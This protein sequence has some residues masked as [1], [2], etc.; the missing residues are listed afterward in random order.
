VPG[1]QGASPEDQSSVYDTNYGNMPV[2]ATQFAGN[3]AALHSLDKQPSV[4]TTAANASVVMRADRRNGIAYT[5]GYQS[6]R[7][8]GPQINNPVRSSGFQQWLIGP[9]VDFILN[10]CLY[11]AGYPAATISYGTNRNLAWS[12]RVAQIPT[13]ATGGPGPGAMLPAPRFQS[14]QTV[15]RYSTMPTMYNTQSSPG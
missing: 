13:M 5:G 15:P 6:R 9:Q 11:R 8:V 12:T 7:D 4:L 3:V 10:N 2:P 1:V 14:V